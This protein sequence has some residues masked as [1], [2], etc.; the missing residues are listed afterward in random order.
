MLTFYALAGSRD[1][2][3]RDS[4][5]CPHAEEEGRLVTYV[6]TIGRILTPSLP[7]VVKQRVESDH[8]WG[9]ESLRDTDSWPR[10][11]PR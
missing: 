10:M 6:K 2:N 4:K 3:D 8:V 1:D 7:L 9:P 11:G 5:H